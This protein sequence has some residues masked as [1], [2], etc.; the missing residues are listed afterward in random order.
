MDIELVAS[1]IGSLGFPIIIS[2]VMIKM[3]EKEQD[4]HKE[5]IR[6]LS[7]EHKAESKGFTEAY[8]ANT[9]ILTELKQLLADKLEGH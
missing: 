6:L 5:E 9:V 3:L 7:E 4:A 8:Q 2:V 1:L